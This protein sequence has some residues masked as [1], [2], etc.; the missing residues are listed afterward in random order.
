MCANDSFRLRFDPLL[1]SIQECVLLLDE[2]GNI[3]SANSYAEK[4]LGYS[5]AEF[6]SLSY[7]TLDK[8]ITPIFSAP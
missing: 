1:E 4:A 7:F 3:R 8:E 6:K 5:L 2:G